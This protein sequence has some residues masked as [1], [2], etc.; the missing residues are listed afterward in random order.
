LTQIEKSAD[1]I[2]QEIEGLRPEFES[3]ARVSMWE[4]PVVEAGIEGNRRLKYALL[5]G[6]AVLLA[7]LGLV[8]GLEYRNRRIIHGDEVSSALGLRVIGTVPSLP[9]RA[10]AR[11]AAL[12][13]QIP[14]WQLHLAESIDNTRTLLLHGLGGDLPVRTIMVTSAT[15]GEGKTSLSGHLAVSLARAGFKTLLVDADMRRPALNNVL[16]TPLTPGLSELLQGEAAIEEV[17]R[18]TPAFGLSMIPAGAWSARLPRLLAGNAWK[19]LKPVLEAEFDFVIVDSSPLLPV[20]DSLLLARHVDGVLL[21]LLHDVSRLGA[22]AEA[23]D[24]LSAVGTNIL[25]V[26]I[27]GV[28]SDVYGASY[29]GYRLRPEMAASRA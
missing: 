13:G 8:A 9:R 2:Y 22:V 16:G 23:K 25:G 10:L 3:Q 24:R 20:A 7:G 14:D 28:T 15:S 26:V 17:V 18:A 5:A 21:S 27:N 1:R 11:G 29:G 6:L 12:N 19:D 4:E